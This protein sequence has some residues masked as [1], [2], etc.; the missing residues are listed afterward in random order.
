VVGRLRVA[1][2]VVILVDG[3]WLYIDVVQF[4]IGD[5]GSLIEVVIVFG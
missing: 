4:I 3:V 5:M 2:L 1:P